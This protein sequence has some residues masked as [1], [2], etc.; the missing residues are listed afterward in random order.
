MAETGAL[1]VDIVILR[2][3]LRQWVLSIPNFDIHQCLRGKLVVAN[4]VA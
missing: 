3:A 1:L 4:F 2:V